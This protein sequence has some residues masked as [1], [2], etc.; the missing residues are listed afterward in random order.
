M[1]ATRL[2]TPNPRLGRGTSRALG[3]LM[4]VGLV[5][6]AALSGTSSTALHK[7]AATR[8]GTSFRVATFNLLGANHTEHSR[9]FDTYRPRTRKAIRLIHDHNFSIVGLQ[10]FQIPQYDLWS[11]REGDSWGVYPG[12]EEGRRP[13]QNS[14]VWR[15]DTW[16]LVEKHT[17]SIPYFHGKMVPEPY[18]QLRNKNTGDAV[19]VIDTHNPANSHGPAE[20]Y[21]NRAERIQIDL[22]NELKSTGVPVLLVG[23]FNET[24]DAFCHITGNTSLKSANPGSWDGGTCHPPRQIRI[25]WI[26]LSSSLESANYTALDTAF[27]HKI[28]DHKVIFSDITIP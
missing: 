25:D 28:T 2:S 7:S 23:D 17:Y 8:S 19:W 16:S 10:E 18:V 3:V 6:A 4:A 22:V 13:V 12:M 27:V 15:K 26:F 11:A 5:L 21:R 24:R 9:R 1:S 20:R 14:V